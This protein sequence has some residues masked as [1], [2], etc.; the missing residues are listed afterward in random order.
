MREAVRTAKEMGF[1]KIV[2]GVFKDNTRAMRLYEKSGFEMEARE[3]TEVWIDG[4]WRTGFI[5]G[6][7]LAPCRPKLKQSHLKD[8]NKE[9]TSISDVKTSIRQLNDLDLDELNRLQNSR[10]STKSSFRI[11]PFTKEQTKRWY[12]GIKSQEN[13]YCLADFNDDKL[14]GYILFKATSAPF[15]CLRFEEILVDMDRN[16]CHTASALVK[17]TI[18]FK[19][20]YGYHRISLLV[21]ENS[22][23]IISALESQGFKKG[24]AVK[25]YY[26][27]DDHY[28]NAAMYEH[29]NKTKPV[30]T[31]PRAFP[32]TTQGT[33]ALSLKS[34]NP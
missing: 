6:R 29:C 10:Q 13:K 11:P 24:G 4:S 19:E 1:R 15:F 8:S 5:M 33:R 27:I 17:A 16:P 14:L 20:R 34:L 22:Y 12:E 25:D 23:P 28:T 32:I 18:D 21:P 31:K 7:E 9:Q 30:R 3:K 2:L 26:F